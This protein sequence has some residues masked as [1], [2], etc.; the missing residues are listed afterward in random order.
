MKFEATQKLVQYELDDVDTC[1][2]CSNVMPLKMP[3]QEYV[4]FHSILLI[5]KISSWLRF[6][7]FSK[8]E[9]F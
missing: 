8:F 4:I 2:R 7:I 5:N 6:T 9:L 3:E 1:A